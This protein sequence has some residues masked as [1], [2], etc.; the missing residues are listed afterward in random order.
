MSLWDSLIAGGTGKLHCWDGT[1]FRDATWAEVARDAERMT[2]GLHEAGVEPGSSVA[3]ILTNTPGT[4]RGVLAT[5]LAGGV[6]ASLPVPAR[7]MGMDAYVEQISRICRRI[8]ARTLLVDAALVELFPADLRE[9]FG[10]TSWESVEDS[11]IAAAAPPGDEDPAFIQFSSGS[12][13]APKGCV[14]TPRAIAAQLRMI[15]TMLGAVPGQETDVSWL[16]LSHDMGMF[17]NLLTPWAYDEDLV[18]SSPER[19]MMSPRTWFDDIAASGATISC[20]TNGALALA[21]RSHRAPLARRLRLHT[22][23][24]GAER[25]QW[26]T[27]ES[28]L[29]TFGSSG[30]EAKHLMPA[31]GLA[32][33]VLAVTATPRDEEPRRLTVDGSA[34]G[35]GRVEEV[36]DD[37][38]GAAVVVAAGVPCNGVELHGLHSQEL[39]ELV[40]SSPSLANG[41][42]GDE[43]R[44]RERF[45]DGRLRTRDLAFV[46]ADGWLYPVGRTDDLISIG[47]RKIYACEIEEGVDGLEGVRR[48]C[49]TVIETYRGG[50]QRLTLLIE[51]TGQD[52]LDRAASVAAEAAEVA[53]Y[54]AAVSIDD[55]VFLAKG[56]LPKTPSG[57]IQRYRCREMLA[58][59]AF[60]PIDQVELAAV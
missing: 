41:Y 34:L 28:A 45:V 40:V 51:L 48:G 29:E 2:V 9:R 60:E 44:S 10:V 6:L 30:L 52:A 20:G 3:A 58:E 43:E 35:L 21:A 1:R 47:G 16:P 57:K 42:F 25:L 7:G 13:S 56:T 33:A 50:R 59:Q 4:V 54:R 49:S 12:T 24:L 8:E 17:G 5:W 26:P 37:A 36:A 38:P 23:I 39:D 46:D 15:M 53:M 14:L 22:I 19:F 27:L 31:Y 55:C 32:E 11:G 18:L